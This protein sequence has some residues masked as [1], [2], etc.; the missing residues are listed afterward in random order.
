MLF[1]RIRRTQKPVF[2]FLAVM[3]GLGFVALGVGQG[4]N[5]IDL[6]SL[7]SSS[8]SGGTSIS[9]LQSRVQD[10]PKDATAWLQLARAYQ[11]DN[12]TTPAITAYQT[13]LNLKPKDQTALA[14]AAALLEQRGATNAQKVLRYRA[15]A[16]AYT[17]VNGA[18]AASSLKLSAALSH[19]LLQTLAQ[20]FTTKVS[21]FETSAITDYA[22]A[23]GMRQKIAKLSPQDAAAQLALARD[24]YATQSYGTVATA[25][26]AY[27]D[28]SPNLTKAQKA[29]LR[30][31]VAQFR[32]LAKQSATAGSTTSPGG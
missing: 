5:S 13:Y 18:T 8:S 20:P 30:Q 26:Q 27:L 17:Q 31:Q 21:T 25:L 23:M 11:G 22:Q 1:E 28:L 29:Q 3:F 10:H 6:G 2:I 12:Q 14:A 16:Q 15:L 24:A 7:F 32:L 4:A 19:P 9:D